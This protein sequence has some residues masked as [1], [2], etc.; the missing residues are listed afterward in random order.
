MFWLWTFIADSSCSDNCVGA[1]LSARPLYVDVVVQQ[2]LNT[3]KKYVQT[4]KLFVVQPT[5][6]YDLGDCSCSHTLIICL[7]FQCRPV[8]CCVGSRDASLW[9]RC[10]RRRFRWCCQVRLIFSCC[11]FFSLFFLLK[12]MHTHTKHYLICIYLLL[13]LIA[14][15]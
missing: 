4:T 14:F 1:L 9:A 8:A 6:C 15:I 10:T 7:H 11:L 5:N 12:H 13:L 2:S 3:R